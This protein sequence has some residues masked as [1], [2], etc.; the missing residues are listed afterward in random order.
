MQQDSF[1]ADRHAEDRKTQA[2]FQ[3][4]AAKCDISASNGLIQEAS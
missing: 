4:S 2:T 1:N 3:P